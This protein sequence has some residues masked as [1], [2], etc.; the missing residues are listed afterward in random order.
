MLHSAPLLLLLLGLTAAPGVHSVKVIRPAQ[1]SDQ[2]FPPDA[3]AHP[4]FQV[5]WLD[6][7]P[8]RNATAHALLFG[9]GSSEDID[10]LTLVSQHSAAEGHGRHQ[11]EGRA[12]GEPDTRAGSSGSGIF[13]ALGTPLSRPL[14]SASHS[15][16]LHFLDQDSPYLCAIPRINSTADKYRSSPE[17][18]PT[19]AIEILQQGLALLEPL[20]PPSTP[21]SKANAGNSPTGSASHCLY[22]TYD[23]FT[24]SYC[25]GRAVT[26]FRA[27]P[28]TVGSAVE[29][30][31]ALAE[32]A[33][34]ANGQSV[35]KRIEP[36]KD[37][38]WPA[39]VLGRWSDDVD[40]LLDD[41]GTLLFVS[42]S[43]SGT[44]AQNDLVSKS[45]DKSGPPS[46]SSSQQTTQLAVIPVSSVDTTRAHIHTALIEV[47][48]FDDPAVQ[49]VAAEKDKDGAQFRRAAEAAAKASGGKAA[50]RSSPPSS[51]VAVSSSSSSSGSARSPAI[52]QRYI[53]QT[54]SDGTPETTV[55]RY[56]VVIETSRLCSIPALAVGRR[57]GSGNGGADDAHS[58][59]C[60][61]IVRDDW[62]SETALREF[63][64]DKQRREEEA[65]VALRK[66]IQAQGGLTLR[67]PSSTAS[68]PGASEATTAASS[69]SDS[70]SSGEAPRSERRKQAEDRMSKVLSEALAE[71]FGLDAVQT[72]Q[73]LKPREQGPQAAKVQ[74][75]AK[76]V[77]SQEEYYDPK[78]Q[79]GERNAADSKA[80]IQK[81]LTA[82]DE[83]LNQLL[84][85]MGVEVEVQEVRV[86]T[87]KE[88]VVEKATA[89]TRSAVGG[90]T[91]SQARRAGAAAVGQESS[92]A[93]EF[94]EDEMVD[95][96]L[97][98]LGLS[99][100]MEG[101]LGEVA[102]AEAGRGKA[103]KEAAD[104]RTSGS[105]QHPDSAK[106][107]E[108]SGDAARSA[109]Q[110]H[111]EL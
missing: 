82:I 75:D 88:G 55:C 94:T 48:A 17:S 68:S 4:A 10:E 108:K 16:E 73:F 37:P 71:Y 64:A 14:T 42:S 63:E 74:D 31:S 2:R 111:G 84:K 107:E 19:S 72:E 13:S 40:R 57:S 69:S 98:E 59:D 99:D 35:F 38:Q 102:E 95:V 8:L 20:K 25:H 79:G 43:E 70:G 34:G 62:D 24:Y 46:S 52:S 50:S 89:S 97:D 77:G 47:V 7:E 27:L 26:Q 15:L 1:T 93:E 45:S 32:S 5:A 23:W 54:W 85:D 67:T 65:M 66:R 81:R 60:R 18:Q 36:R 110:L 100:W 101:A 33:V 86:M 22:Y 21:E 90:E 87:T 12:Q 51:D 104:A 49:H 11:Q 44:S 83:R 3:F 28:Q 80:G 103:T 92:Q 58:I 109:P 91:A 96:L 9:P 76:H 39:Y 30:A 61:P 29:L 41:D 6:R 106:E 53:S 105:G 56:V 78:A